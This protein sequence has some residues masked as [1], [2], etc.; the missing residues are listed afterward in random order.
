MRDTTLEG[1]RVRL[2]RTSD[3]YT[4]LQLGEEGTVQFV[5]DLGTLHVKWDSGSSLGLVPGE[6][7]WTTITERA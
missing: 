6:D 7:S 1:Q 3:P 2:V 5:D 4:R